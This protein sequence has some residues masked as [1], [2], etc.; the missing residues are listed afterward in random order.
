LGA[1]PGILGTL[2]FQ[3]SHNW[4]LWIA[5]LVSSLA[6]IFFLLWLR[7]KFFPALKVFRDEDHAIE[8]DFK[9][10]GGYRKIIR[11]IKPRNLDHYD[12]I[13]IC[14]RAVTA[15]VSLIP[16]ITYALK[17]RAKVIVFVLNPDFAQRPKNAEKFNDLEPKLKEHVIK[18]VL[19]KL[20]NKKL[21]KYIDDSKLKAARKPLEDCLGPN[22]I[23][24]KAFPYL[25]HLIRSMII[26]WTGI[27]DRCNQGSPPDLKVYGL[28]DSS[29]LYKITRIACNNNTAEPYKL[30]YYFIGVNKSKDVGTRNP[31]MMLEAKGEQFNRD[32]AEQVNR[33]IEDLLKSVQSNQAKQLVPLPEE[34]K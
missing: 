19:D 30:C 16:E 28:D 6:I 2:G 18:E 4:F 13:V 24:N 10:W 1:I 20:K 21:L 17:A 7:E 29:Q 34:N 23:S 15:V 26:I 3:V 22:A 8:G 5:G 11:D 25:E 32:F 9:I 33:D 12:E 27:Y 31:I 14:G